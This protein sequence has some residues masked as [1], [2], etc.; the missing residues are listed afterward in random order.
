MVT[1]AGTDSGR[2]RIPNLTQRDP[3]TKQVVALTCTNE[4][5]SEMFHKAFFPPSSA[6]AAPPPHAE[7]PIAAWQFTNFSDAQID[8]AIN[9]IN[10]AKATRPDSIPNVMIK[11]CK[12]L[13]LSYLGPLF[14]A[15]VTLQ[16]YPPEWAHT[17]TLVLRKPGKTDYSSPSSWRPIVLSDGLAHLLNSCVAEEITTMCEQCSILP[18]HHF[19]G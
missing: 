13:L 14:R 3:V 9:R 4:E 5:K 19:G 17:E 1:T 2:A 18:P 15:T 12:V 16:H 6:T 11:E 7:Y 8:R 10:P